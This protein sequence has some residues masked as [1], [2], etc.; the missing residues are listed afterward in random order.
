MYVDGDTTGV[1][2]GG[3]E[4]TIRSFINENINIEELNQLK[5]PLIDNPGEE[6][7]DVG[8]DGCNNTI[9]NGFGSCLDTL[10]FAYWC[11]SDNDLLM[12]YT[13]VFNEHSFNPITNDSIPINVNICI[14]FLNN[15]ALLFSPF[16]LSLFLFLPH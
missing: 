4:K 5:I 13:D 1:S 15:T 9:E 8:I 2:I 11:N 10:T 14:D 12:S 3:E 7:N 16:L 6:L